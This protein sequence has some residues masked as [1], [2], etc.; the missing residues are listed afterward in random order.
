MNDFLNNQKQE[1][2][3]GFKIKFTNNLFNIHDLITLNKNNEIF[4][5]RYVKAPIEFEEIDNIF[6]NIKSIIDFNKI[7]LFNDVPTF[8]ILE[9]NDNI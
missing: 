3:F 1:I 4:I 5:G 2:F 9:E 7:I 8:I 6:K